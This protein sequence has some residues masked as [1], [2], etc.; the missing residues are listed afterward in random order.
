MMSVSPEL[1]DEA[2]SRWLEAVSPCRLENR[3][4]ATLYIHLVSLRERYPQR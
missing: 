4:N 3:K 1:D 2:I